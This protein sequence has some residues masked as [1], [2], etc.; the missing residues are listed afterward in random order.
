MFRE[1]DFI[2]TAEGLIFDVKGLVHPPD[3]V[4]AFVRYFPSPEGDRER[5]GIRYRKVYD[6]DERFAFLKEH[7]PQYLVYDPVLGETMIEVP[8]E[9]VARHYLPIC[10]LAELQSSSNINSLEEKTL[11]FVD[12]IMDAAHVPRGKVGVSGSILV[13]LAS[14]SS[15]LDLIIYGVENA[16]KVDLALKKHFEEGGRL[17]KYGLEMLKTLHEDRCRESGVSFEDY[18]FHEQRK[19]F[20]GFFDET[21]FFIRYVK[22]RGEFNETYG[23]YVYTP[24][25]R[26]KIR[27]V[28]ADDRDALFTPCSYT[29]ED[30]KIIEGLSN[31]PISSIASFRGRFCEQAVDGETIIACGK[32][33]RVKHGGE[34]S[35]RLI[36][37]NRPEDFMVVAGK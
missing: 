2:E 25:G 1:G 23:E 3:R 10:K 24:I 8:A 9:R 21:E 28:V 22:D 4:I 11:D 30:V 14:P 36:L 6:L 5:H 12:F 34:T 37:G 17:K 18:L 19:S 15:D 35:Y 33:E 7:F 20:Q 13:G 31:V 26:S 29:V 32:L 27:G 16:M